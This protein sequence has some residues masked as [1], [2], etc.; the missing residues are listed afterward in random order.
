MTVS[1]VI[2]TYNG[3]HK[4]AGVIESLRAQTYKEF[5]L[6]I[7]VDGSTD[8][9]KEML[10]QMHLTFAPVKIIYQSNNGRA[11]VRN[12]GASEASG[13]LLVFFDDDM[14][15]DPSCIQVH[16]DHHFKFPSSILTGAQ[17]DISHDSRTDIQVLKSFYSKVK[18]FRIFQSLIKTT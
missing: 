11:S 18:I 15:P 16:V 7:V 6:V 10:E 8:N 17:V 2:S 1:V 13:E 5:E 9:T 12:R 3:A 14:L 4:I